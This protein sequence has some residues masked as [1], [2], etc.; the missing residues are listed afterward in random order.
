MRL[1]RPNDAPARIGG[2]LPGV[3]LWVLQDAI[4]SGMALLPH[5][6]QLREV[7]DRAP[8]N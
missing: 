4:L 6:R 3:T 1:L 2:G 8:L 7:F 5:F